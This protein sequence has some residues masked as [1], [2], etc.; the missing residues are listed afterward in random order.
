MP[1]SKLTDALSNRCGHCIV[2]DHLYFTNRLVGW[3]LTALSAQI[4]HIMPF[5]SPIMVVQNQPNKQNKIE[6]LN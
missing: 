1:E 2:I 5:I 4:G 3:G 6:I